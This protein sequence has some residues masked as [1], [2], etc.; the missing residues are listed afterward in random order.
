MKV[1]TGAAAGML[2]VVLW[3]GGAVPS[4]QGVGQVSLDAA[5][6]PR[7]WPGIVIHHSATQSGSVESIDA[8]H[9]DVRG[10]DGIGYHFV[11]GNGEGMADGQVV[12][13]FRWA[14]QRNGAHC[15]GHNNRIGICLI[16]DFTKGEP[17]ARQKESLRRLT[18]AL[19]EW[20]GPG[21]EVVGHRCVPGA[22]TACPGSLDVS[23]F[24]FQ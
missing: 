4:D 22:A 16:G 19:Q 12:P 6:K 14:E 13:T 7:V 15:V 24:T 1:L 2:C 10:W 20:C 3:V 21:S 17:T 8:Y 23:E 9:R 5:A 18:R 11:I